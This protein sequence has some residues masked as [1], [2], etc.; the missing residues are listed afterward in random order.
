MQVDG[1]K[2]LCGNRGIVLCGGRPETSIRNRGSVSAFKV[3][4]IVPAS[5]G[6]HSWS[7][8][9]LFVDSIATF[10]IR[11]ARTSTQPPKEKPPQTQAQEPIPPPHPPERTSLTVVLA[12]KKLRRTISVFFRVWERRRRESDFF[13]FQSCDP[14]FS[15]SDSAHIAA[16]PR[17]SPR[18]QSTV[19]PTVR[20]AVGDEV[21]LL[22]L[23]VQRPHRSRALSHHDAATGGTKSGRS[24]RLK[25]P[26]TFSRRLRLEREVG[27]RGATSSLLWQDRPRATSQSPVASGPSPKRKIRKARFA[28]PI[29]RRDGQ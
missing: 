14:V 23:E 18:S 3:H 7:S 8:H 29:F 20:Q 25:S 22:A 17:D 28:R 12:L 21:L 26:T 15:R 24:I 2:V 13:F 4:S 16:C 1:A 10:F 19:A 27:R 6:N 5:W 9:L 11:R